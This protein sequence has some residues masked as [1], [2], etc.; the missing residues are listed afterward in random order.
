MHTPN[1]E[2]YLQQMQAWQQGLD[3]PGAERRLK[4]MIAQGNPHAAAYAVRRSRAPG[5]S[6]AP[7]AIW[8]GS[9]WVAVG[10]EKHPFSGL[11]AEKYR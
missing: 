4:K 2:R 5:A 11:R 10:T 6:T 7:N 8:D 1:D 9:E 3:A